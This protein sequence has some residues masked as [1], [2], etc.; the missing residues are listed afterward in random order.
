VLAASIRLYTGH[1][2]WIGGC[3]MNRLRVLITHP[4]LVRVGGGNAVSAW[5]IQALSREHDVT[6]ATLDAPDCD[7]LNATFGTHLSLEDFEVRVAP[8]GYQ[9]LRRCMPTQGALANICLTM[10]WAQDLD[11]DEHFDVLFSTQDEADFHRRGIQYVHYPWLYMPRPEQELSWYHRVPGTLALYRKACITFARAT[12]AGLRKNVTLANSKFVAAR[13]EASQGTAAQVI[14]PPVPGEFEETPWNRR[15]M[16]IAAVGRLNPCKRWD[17]AIEIVEAARRKGHDLAFTL[18]GHSE[19]DA[20]TAH[21]EAMAATRPWFRLLKNVDRARLLAELAGHRYGIH[22]MPEEHFG[23]APAELQRAG[24]ITFVHNSGGPV[25]IVGGDARL[26]FDGV[27]DA[28]EKIAAAIE[29]P[30]L[31]RELVGQ[32][33]ERRN[34]FSTERFCDSIRDVV[35]EF[36]GRPVEAAHRTRTA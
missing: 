21:L 14:F 31:E 20:Y 9:L 19:I 29:T 34:W 16:A 30:A 17:M 1:Y 5:A 7:A 11:R 35:A 15:R 22:T 6:L 8:R 4:R 12:P 2:A 32:I 27:E 33:A 28:A 10:R 3:R 26:T 18:I 25:E 13:I 24:C 36:A 23:I